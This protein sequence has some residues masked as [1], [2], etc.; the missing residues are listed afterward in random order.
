M[1]IAVPAV[2]RMTLSPL[3]WLMETLRRRAV[4][5]LDCNHSTALRLVNNAQVNARMLLSHMRLVMID[6]E[7]GAMLHGRGS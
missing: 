4:G 2:S 6:I 5:S 3:T 1:T 7:G